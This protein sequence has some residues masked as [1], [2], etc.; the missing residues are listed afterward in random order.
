VASN[1]V[2]SASPPRENGV[3]RGIG[4]WKVR[5]ASW[6]IGSLTSKLLELVKSLHRHRISIACIQETKWV[7]PKA[8]EVDGYKL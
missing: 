7:G 8:R 5:L 3:M 4:L 2:G 6:N 1:V